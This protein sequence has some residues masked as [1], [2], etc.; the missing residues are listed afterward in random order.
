[1]PLSL[2]ALSIVDVPV[3]L[4]V[5]THGDAPW[6]TV[7][8]YHGFRADALAHAAEL[9]RCAEAGFLAVGVDAVAHGVRRDHTLAERVATTEGSAMSVMLSLV[10][11]SLL[12]LP[13]LVSALV[14]S[15]NADAARISLVGISMGAFLAYRAIGIGLPLRAVVALL[16]SP[17]QAGANSPH[18]AIEAFGSVALLSVVAEHDASVPPKAASAFHD[19]LAT[20]YGNPN[21]HRHHLLRGAGHLTNALQ[22]EEAMRVTMDWLDTKAR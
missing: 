20:R 17:E 16:G 1:M 6:P 7:L 22:W 10:D 12:E 5:P 11:E 21:L 15:H 14:K 13:A 3:L 9:E 19:A 2:H 8:W 4:G 18:D